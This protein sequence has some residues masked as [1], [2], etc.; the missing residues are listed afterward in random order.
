MKRWTPK[1][2]QLLQEQSRQSRQGLPLTPGNGLRLS[3]PADPLPSLPG[4][5]IS[6][7]QRRAMLRQLLQGKPVT[8]TVHGVLKDRFT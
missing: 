2:I 1:A 3:P 5:S 8:F 4:Q 7:R 6:L